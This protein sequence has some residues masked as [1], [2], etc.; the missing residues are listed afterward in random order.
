MPKI[1]VIIPTYNRAHYVSQAIDSVLAQTFTDYE[2]LVIDDG[3]IDNTKEVLQSYLDKITYIY[4]ENKGVSA[5]RNTGLRL[6]RGE[7]IAFLDSDDIW[8]PEKLEVQF[9]DV[10]CHGNID[11]H[12]CNGEYVDAHTTQDI[13]FLRRLKVYEGSSKLLSDPFSHLIKF[14]YHNLQLVLLKRKAIFFDESMHNSEDLVYLGMIALNSKYWLL[15]NDKLV[16]IIRRPEAGGISLTQRYKDDFRYTVKVSD[17]VFNI[18]ENYIVQN[19][20]SKKYLNSIKVFQSNSYFTYS[21][22]SRNKKEATEY[23]FNGLTKNVTMRN[24][25]KYVFYYCKIFFRF[26]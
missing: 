16:R 19:R 22:L 11:L 3:S 5:A 9:N 14:Q 4:Q 10:C 8:L 25:V 1:S 6:A 26:I 7:W 24:I 20:Y 12:V 18:L 2:I 23:I 13:F 17:N 15:R 21:K